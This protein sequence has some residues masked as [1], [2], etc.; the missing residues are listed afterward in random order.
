MKYD[1]LIVG[2]GFFG[3]VFA[4]EAKQAGKRVLVVDKRPYIGGNVYTENIEGIMYTS[5]G[6]IFSI[7]I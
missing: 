4:H 2:A 6:L 7:R 3:S 5:T 1:Y